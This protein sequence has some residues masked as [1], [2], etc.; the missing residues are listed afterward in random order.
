MCGK[1]KI[2][3]LQ[4]SAQKSVL[5]RREESFGTILNVEFGLIELLTNYFRKWE[6]VA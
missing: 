2:R 6:F 3:I 5:R 1:E 4:N